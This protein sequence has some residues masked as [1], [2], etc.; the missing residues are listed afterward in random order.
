[1][2][3]SNEKTELAALWDDLM[4][5]NR[6][7]ER[8]LHSPETWSVVVVNRGQQ[9]DAPPGRLSARD[10]QILERALL[11]GVRKLVAMEV[12]LSC[13]SVA[14]ILQSCFQFI[15]LACLP[16]RIPALLV[17]AAHARRCPTAGSGS[18]TVLSG[19]QFSPQTVSVVRPDK[20][21]AHWLAPAEHEVMTQ[22]IEGNSYAEIARLRGTS[23]R[24]VANQ[25]TS[26]F[27]R[28]GVSGRAEL[29]CLLARWGLEATPNESEP[30]KAP[31]PKGKRH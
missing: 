26:A 2:F 27:R 1:M 17:A 18:S 12:G 5:G 25:I 9:T 16:S 13:S 20:A 8:A 30:P 21:L 3:A 19:L 4:A 31:G 7:I 14:T 23:V 10:E 28:L 15:G 29:L 24:T 22:L 6:K 11:C